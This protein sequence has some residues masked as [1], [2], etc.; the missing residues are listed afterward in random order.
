MKILTV[1]VA[2][3]AAKIDR[4][5]PFSLLMYG[6]GEFTVAD[7]ERVGKKLAAGEVV[8]QRLM[9]EMQASFSVKPLCL[10]PPREAWNVAYFA[11]DPSLL[12]P[13]LYQG[14]DVSAVR[15]MSERG[16]PWFSKVEEWHDGVVWDRASRESGLEPFIRAVR[17]K[18]SVLVGCDKLLDV[19]YPEPDPAGGGLGPLLGN[20]GSVRVPELN[21]AAELD[22]IE[23]DVSGLLTEPTVVVCCMGLGAIP[24]ICRLRKKHPAC[25]F[26]DLGSVLDV[27]ARIGE[28]RGWRNEMYADEAAWRE[29]VRRNLEGA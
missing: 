14:R 13:D 1:P 24:L 25:T 23:R 7:G 4:G 16:R 5:E 26:L 18:R 19:R 9:D 6:D 29:C 11:S 10:D 15:M 28:Q 12:D 2:D 17:K 27:F 21:A 3:Y 22:R 20:F 8:T